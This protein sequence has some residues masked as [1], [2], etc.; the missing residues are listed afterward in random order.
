MAWESSESQNALVEQS[1][2]E[3]NSSQF[4]GCYKEEADSLQTQVVSTNEVLQA[5]QTVLEE[6]KDNIFTKLIDQFKWWRWIFVWTP[7]GKS[8]LSLFWKKSEQDL[9]NVLANQSWITTLDNTSNNWWG[10]SLQDREKEPGDTEIVPI[11]EYISGI[12]YDIKYATTD[13][14]AKKKMYESQEQYLKLQ[15]QAIKKLKKAEELAQSQW[16]SIKIWDAYRPAEAQEALWKWY[17][18][19]WLPQSEKTKN[20]AKPVSLWWKWSN[21]WRWTAIDLTLVDKDWNELEMPTKF[22]EFWVTAHWDS[23]NR[24]SN[25]D[26]KKKNALKLKEIMTAA[27]FTTYKNEWWH[28]ESNA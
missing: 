24:L 1:Q 18:E 10:E 8:I 14:F 9:G 23:V 27:W 20:V 28:F 3:R 5:T 12:K 19:A 6:H 15:Y 17:D 7:L 25:N 26:I 4:L 21:H 2:I 11:K 13:N 22:D 16:L